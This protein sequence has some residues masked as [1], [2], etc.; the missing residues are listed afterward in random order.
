MTPGIDSVAISSSTV[1]TISG[2]VMMTTRNGAM[3]ACSDEKPTVSKR[4][5]IAD[6]SA[7]PSSQL[8]AAPVSVCQKNQRSAPQSTVATPKGI[9]VSQS[10]R[11]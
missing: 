9:S 6:V 4:R 5:Y 11:G 1:T 10:M 7:Q 2:T 8:F 3:T